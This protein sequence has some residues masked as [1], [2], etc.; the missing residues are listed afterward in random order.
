MSAESSPRQQV[1][2]DE[3]SLD[4][5]QEELNELAASGVGTKPDNQ[6]LSA[7]IGAS[8]TAFE[9]NRVHVTN[10]EDRVQQQQSQ[11]EEPD[12]TLEKLTCVQQDTLRNAYQY[13]EFLT[14]PFAPRY[15]RTFL[16]GAYC[17]LHGKV[18]AWMSISIQ[19]PAPLTILGLA[20][21]ESKLCISSDG[22]AIAVSARDNTIHVFLEGKLLHKLIVRSTQYPDEVCLCQLF[23]T[24]EDGAEYSLVFSVRGTAYRAVVGGVYRC[25]KLPIDYRVGLA[26]A[27]AP[28]QEI[29]WRIV[30]SDA[31]KTSVDSVYSMNSVSTKTVSSNGYVLDATTTSGQP[32]G[33]VYLT[34][35]RTAKNLQLLVDQEGNAIVISRL[36]HHVDSSP[37]IKSI[38]NFAQYSVKTLELKWSTNW[39]LNSTQIVN[40]RFL[41]KGDALVAYARLMTSE[42]KSHCN[43]YATI[44]PLSS[45]H[46]LA[47]QVRQE[48]KPTWVVLDVIDQT[49]SLLSFTKYFTSHSCQQIPLV[50]RELP[51]VTTQSA[52]KQQAQSLAQE[53]KST[54]ANPGFVPVDPSNLATLTSNNPMVLAS[55]LQRY[56][57]NQRRS[58]RKPVVDA[59]APAPA[60]AKQPPSEVKSQG[61]H[62]PAPR[63]VRF[64]DSV[65]SSSNEHGDQL[66]D[67][68]ARALNGTKL[69]GDPT[70]K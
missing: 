44:Y 5:L 26:V 49:I 51:P 54:L 9:T 4:T 3:D 43:H 6:S 32:V 68:V 61:T 17:V 2:A 33:R 21:D 28:N 37:M 62:K 57:S 52:T 69:T 64:R 55:Q 12:N 10:L 24:I 59:P 53:K 15:R 27:M 18:V 14:A 30:N 40:P 60:P 67:E 19:G 56:R 11:A 35:V 39:N 16:S 63:S 50:K 58:D 65:A 22:R 42:L 36:D 41:L 47:I 70:D 20:H 31:V 34:T 46:E 8:V 29:I 66:E 45:P 7:S 13:I 38:I 23:P 1:G 48:S 25:E